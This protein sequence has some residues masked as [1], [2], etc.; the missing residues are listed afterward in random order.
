MLGAPRDIT[1]ENI[2]MYFDHEAAVTRRPFY[3]RASGAEWRLAT[4]RKK[5]DARI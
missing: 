4:P 2:Y 3:K 1:D 5:E